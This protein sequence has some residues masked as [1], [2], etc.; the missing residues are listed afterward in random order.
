[1]HSPSRSSLHALRR[2]RAPVPLLGATAVFGG[3]AL[4]AP[5]ARAAM[6][7]LLD[8]GAVHLPGNYKNG[9]SFT[10]DLPALGATINDDAFGCPIT[11]LSNGPAERGTAEYHDYAPINAV[12]ADDTKVLVESGDG[13]WLV[14][15][16]TGQVVAQASLASS[17]VP[18]TNSNPGAPRWSSD[19]STFYTAVGN[20]LYSVNVASG[21][22]VYALVS[23][24]S[25]YTSV[26]F[27]PHSD[28]GADGDHVGLQGTKTDGSTKAFAFQV[29]TRTRY[30][31]V[32]ISLSDHGDEIEITPNNQVLVSRASTSV[33][34]YQ[35]SDMT[36]LRTLPALGGWHHGI[37]RAVDGSDV[38]V[39][40]ASPDTSTSCSSNGIEAIAVDTAVKTCVFPFNWWSD[41]SH[42]SVTNNGWIVWSNTDFPISGRPQSTAQIQLPDGWQSLWLPSLNEVVMMKTDGSQVHHMVHHRSRPIGTGTDDLGGIAS[43]YDE[44]RATVSRDGAV[45]VFDGNWG[46]PDASTVPATA[47][48]ADVYMVQTGLAGAGGGGAQPV[49]WTNLTG[50]AASGGTITKTSTAC[51]G[52]DDSGGNSAQQITSGTGSLL[53]DASSGTTTF[54]MIG[55]SRPG[56]T[57]HYPTLDFAILLAGNGKAQVWEDGNVRVTTNSYAATDT[58]RI[59]VSPASVT[60][61]QN[62]TALYP[63]SSPAIVYP[64]A[65]YASL[66]SLSSSVNDVVLTT[67]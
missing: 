4:S 42:V 44:P 11:R 60:Y 1:M 3:I 46:V 32:A 6:C 43:Y 18:A 25:D 26:E 8:D 28:I 15:N 22:F 54:R 63:N 37:G 61:Y 5:P 40:P 53:F 48:Y 47:A 13:W 55:L 7:G 20:S 49:S 19:P 16:M 17:S 56:T 30:P 51:D 39:L 41:A 27:P 35:M 59:V 12:N 58:F 33:E 62:S 34:V 52:C 21:S 64:L 36:L 31:E 23:T 50:A 14:K 38:Y 24:F 66:W 2:L 9:E 29:S 45:I 67:P 57:V 10:S 65:A